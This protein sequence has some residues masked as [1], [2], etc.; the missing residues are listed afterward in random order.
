MTGTQVLDDELSASPI[1]VRGPLQSTRSP[2]DGEPEDLFAERLLE[3][4]KNRI[5]RQMKGEYRSQ[6]YR[7]NELIG[8]NLSTPLR[9]SEIQIQGANNTRPGFLARVVKPHLTNPDPCED[10]TLESVLH[11]TRQITYA[12]ARTDLFKNIVPELQ[13]PKDP[14]ASIHDVDIVFKCE[15]RGRLSLK[16]ATEVGNGDATASANA[17]VRNAFG[18]AEDLEGSVSF[19]TKTRHTYRLALSAPLTGTMLTRGELSAYAVDNDY[20]AWASCK[21]GLKGV[22]AAVSTITALGQHEVSYQAVLRHIH[23][24]KDEAS[25][26]TRQSAGTTL[27][28]SL[29]YTFVHDTRDDAIMGHRG[30]YLKFNSE[31]AGLGGDSSFAKVEGESQIS[32]RLLKGLHAS[33]AGRAGLLYSLD[34]RPSIFSDRFKLGGPMNVRSFR[35]N[36]IG[37]RDHGDAVGGDAYWAVG[38]SLIGDLPGKAHWPLKP[39]VYVN[40]GKLDN[41]DRG[42]PLSELPSRLASRP[43]V[44]V[45]LGLIYRFDPIRLEVNFGMPLA[46]NRSDGYQR[47]FQIGFGLRVHV[48]S[49]F[50]GLGKEPLHQDQV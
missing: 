21:E 14:L 15:E 30:A 33:L 49:A 20:H 40:A 16:S 24:L 43:S 36:S 8:G 10:P 42:R 9:I 1:E 39:H 4:Q 29:N 12:L 22:K 28:S 48:I 45:G 47:G 18:G 32:R 31:L 38:L 13:T 27:K 34:N 26:S 11:Q 19:G 41:I 3:W 23:S 17:K 2:K 50:I 25:L 6:V 46:A 44:S 7:L 35:Y 5:Q 37:P